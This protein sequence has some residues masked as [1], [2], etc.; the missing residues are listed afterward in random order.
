MSTNSNALDNIGDYKYGFRDPETFVFKSQRGL[1]KKVV[2][3]ISSMK[4]EP[5]WMLDFRLKLWPT[6][7]NVQSQPGVG[8]CLS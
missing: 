8:T 1:S 5:H 4:G 7:S 3:Q 2:E 6:S